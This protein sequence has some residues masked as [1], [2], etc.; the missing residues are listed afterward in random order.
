MYKDIY[1]N[2]CFITHVYSDVMKCPLKEHRSSIPCMKDKDKDKENINTILEKE[3]HNLEEL[4]KDIVERPK[5]KKS[6]SNIVH[7]LA[8]MAE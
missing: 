1:T 7:P 6:S 2:E 8:Y 4:F 5:A 3:I